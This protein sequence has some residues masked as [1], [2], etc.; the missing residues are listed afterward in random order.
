MPSL[1]SKHLA[2][3]VG[4]GPYLVDRGAA[5]TTQPKTVVVFGCG[6]ENPAVPG[7]QL[8]P[9][10]APAGRHRLESPRSAGPAHRCRAHADSRAFEKEGAF[11]LVAAVRGND[12]GDDGRGS[13]F[14]HRDGCEPDIERAGREETLA[15]EFVELRVH[16]VDI[17]L[18]QEL[19]A[20]WGVRGRR[21]ADPEPQRVRPGK[22]AR[23]EAV[24]EA[25]RDVRRH[26]PARQS[27]DDRG[28]RWREELS[29]LGQAGRIRADWGR[30]LR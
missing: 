7:A 19:F 27:G 6:A 13:S 16:V 24:A 22:L 9:N 15:Q 17:R 28:A 21:L 25:I 18:Q 14:L 5:G 26:A 30:I 2:E 29:W 4:L 3:A 1:A 8:E 12:S 10:V 23:T 20:L 11:D